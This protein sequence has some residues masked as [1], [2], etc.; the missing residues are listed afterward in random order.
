MK[1]IFIISIILLFFV[2]CD[3]NDN[4]ISEVEIESYIECPI[5]KKYQVTVEGSGDYA[6]SIEN[7]SIL[8]INY[9]NKNVLEINPKKKGTTQIT[10]HDEVTNKIVKSTIKITDGYCTFQVGNPLRYPFTKN[11]YLYLVYNDTNDLY[12]FDS[13]SK[14]IVKGT[15]LLESSNAGC[16]LSFSFNNAYN[17]INSLLLNLDDN[18]PNKLIFLDKAI[19]NH[20]FAEFSYR[21]R[22]SAPLVLN[23]KN[24]ETGLEYYLIWKNDKIPYH[25]LD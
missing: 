7:S 4:T 6:V 21:G 23:A 16:Y 22:S 12:M 5:G 20:V 24:N 2:S 15:Y 11:V 8:D 13:D 17:S 19:N 18:D 25:I 10:I 1:N 9:A 3:K 14:F